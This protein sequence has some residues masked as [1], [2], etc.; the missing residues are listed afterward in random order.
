VNARA[1]GFSYNISFRAGRD[2]TDVEHAVIIGFLEAH[3]L[4]MFGT[5]EDFFVQRFDGA[6]VTPEDREAFFRAISTATSRLENVLY[7]IS[8]HGYGAIELVDAW[9]RS[10]ERRRGHA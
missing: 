3:G 10:A 9:E 2:A 4:G 1:K 8:A 7:T 6:D 5:F